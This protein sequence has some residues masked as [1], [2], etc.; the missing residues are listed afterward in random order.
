MVNVHKF[1]G[2]QRGILPPSPPPPPP[3][4]PPSFTCNHRQDH[5]DDDDDDDSFE[6]GV[7][8]SASE[9]S[10]G[11]NALPPPGSASSTSLCRRC[12]RRSLSLCASAKP[13]VTRV[14]SSSTCIRL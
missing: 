6:R 5:D 11:S 7:S 3:P 2:R 8:R 10:L 12:A 9:S 1:A 4:P 14:R 13:S